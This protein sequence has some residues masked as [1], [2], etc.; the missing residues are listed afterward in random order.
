MLEMVLDMPKRTARKPVE[1]DSI[2]KGDV[3][4]QSL[5]NQA[6]KLKRLMDSSDLL[7][8]LMDLHRIRVIPDVDGAGVFQRSERAIR[9]RLDRLFTWMEDN[10]YDV[11]EAMEELRGEAES[12]AD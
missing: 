5:L 6:K 11:A 1:K 4:T 10:G 2:R 12:S 8:R 7:S 3:T 9:R